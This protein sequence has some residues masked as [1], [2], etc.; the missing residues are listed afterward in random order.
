MKNLKHLLCA[1]IVA[2]SLYFN[3]FSASSS[4]EE[5]ASLADTQEKAE[6]MEDIEQRYQAAQQLLAL[7]SGIPASSAGPAVLSDDNL[8]KR[9]RIEGEENIGEQPAKYQETGKATF[10][11]S[12]PEQGYASLADTGENAES[13]EDIE[14][15]YQAAQQ[16]LALPSGIPASSAGPAVLSDDNFKKRSERPEETV[17]EQPAKYQRIIEDPREIVREL[18]RLARIEH[19]N[20]FFDAL[21]QET[22]DP[23]RVFNELT[24]FMQHNPE[25]KE[26]KELVTS[27]AYS[28]FSEQPETRDFIKNLYIN[29][30][31]TG[32]D[33]PFIIIQALLDSSSQNPEFHS[34][35]MKNIFQRLLLLE[36]S[37]GIAGIPFSLAIKYL[38]LIK[39]ILSLEQTGLNIKEK[40]IQMSEEGESVN[41]L[42]SINL[43]EFSSKELKLLAHLI[44]LQA[45][46]DTTNEPLSANWQPDRERLITERGDL[47]TKRDTLFASL[48]LDDFRQLLN[49][50]YFL[51]ANKEI[52]YYIISMLIKQIKK[53]YNENF[54]LLESY[55]WF[56]KR[57]I[58]RYGS[59]EKPIRIESEFYDW[60]RKNYRRSIAGLLEFGRIPEIADRIANGI[61]IRVLDLEELDIADL[62]GLQ[63]VP[64]I[65]TA[66]KLILS[67]NEIKRIPSGIF[68]NFVHLH[69]LYLDQNL[70]QE[71]APE[72]FK[73]AYRLRLLDLNH[74]ELE[75]IPANSFEG[76][77]NLRTLDLSSNML[78]TIDPEAFKGLEELTHLDLS[79]NKLENIDL[80][81][82]DHLPKLR[83]I[84]LSDNPLTTNLSTDLDKR[85]RVAPLIHAIGNKIKEVTNHDPTIGLSNIKWG[86]KP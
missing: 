57:D 80:A 17:G 14:Q 72:A 84:N 31:E 86:I 64:D 29:F 83:G 21:N 32:N 81:V 10:G 20:L 40:I 13:M 73:G 42:P 46:I 62:S 27:L 33:Q 5:H 41:P 34:W 59:L 49:V 4:S 60:S 19:R 38:D 74:N 55:P 43:K 58:A 78:H 51:Q 9:E 44:L 47:I 67:N 45:I 54:E 3:A 71:I 12:S 70:I 37:D 8:K 79:H 85:N 82:F 75:K 11:A 25:P 39:N 15:R 50:A 1:G 61:P 2:C 77:G 35:L 26:V 48:S 66:Q 76:L 36:G 28:V 30:V 24:T 22:Q 18:D 69:I 6:S 52:K 53:N 16:L 63:A 23:N 56:I 68:N 65:E 7:P